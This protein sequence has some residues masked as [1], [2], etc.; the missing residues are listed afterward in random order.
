MPPTVLVLFLSIKSFR[1]M[2]FVDEK[3][4]RVDGRAWMSPPGELRKVAARRTLDGMATMCTALKA[5]PIT[6][7]CGRW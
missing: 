4:K 2:A 7:K 5:R 1:M 3:G 6:T